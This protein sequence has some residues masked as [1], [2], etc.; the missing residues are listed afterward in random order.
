LNNIIAPSWKDFELLDSGNGRKLERFGSVVLIRPEQ[1]AYWEPGLSA[2]EWKELAWGEFHD[3]DRGKG[4]WDMRKDFPSDWRL[5]YPLGNRD[6]I[7][8]LKPTRYKHLGVFPEQSINWEHLFRQGQKGERVLNLFAYTGGATQ[9]AAL[10]GCETTH[11]DSVFPMVGWAREN[12]NA[13]GLTD[14]RWI[15]ED[16]M[17]F[18]DRELKRSRTYHR[19]IL[20]PPTYG[21]SKKGGQWKIERDLETLLKK[22]RSLLEKGGEIILNCYSVRMGKDRLLPLLEKCFYRETIVCGRLSLKD[23]FDRLLGCGYLVRIGT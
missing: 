15:C 14:I 19:I 6:I 3:R 10:A 5:G 20:D 12:G 21:F 7:F 2:R 11:I 9:A 16:S 22:S 17:T 4:E 13:A 18:V 1:A 23:N 8:Q